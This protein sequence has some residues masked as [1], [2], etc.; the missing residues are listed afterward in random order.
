VLCAIALIGAARVLLLSAAFPLFN[1][2]D[3]YR[4]LTSDAQR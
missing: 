3:K 1:D 4:V 2:V